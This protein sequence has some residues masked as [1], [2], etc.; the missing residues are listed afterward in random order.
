MLETITSIK[1]EKI[2]LA[3][4]IKIA[5]GATG[6]SQKFSEGEEILDWAIEMPSIEFYPF[7]STRLLQT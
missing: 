5:Q 4:A 3:R 1:D 7:A 2:T 6:F